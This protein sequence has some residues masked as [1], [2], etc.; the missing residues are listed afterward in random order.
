MSPL[1]VKL[2]RTVM[3]IPGL[4]RD[5]DGGFQQ[6]PSLVNNSLRLSTGAGS[7]CANAPDN[8][9][10]SAAPNQQSDLRVCG[11]AGTTAKKAAKTYAWQLISCRPRPA[12]SPSCRDR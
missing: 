1:R 11:A 12:P 4:A 7:A 2:T 3:S 6:L 8:E 10:R 9:N 5:S